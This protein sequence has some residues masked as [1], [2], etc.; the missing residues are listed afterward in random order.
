MA[1][2]NSTASGCQDASPRDVLD[3]AIDAARLAHPLI[4]HGDGRAHVFVPDGYRLED[5]TSP[6]RLPGHIVQ[7]VTVDDRASLVGYANRFRDDRSLIIADYDA[8]R[9]AAR[10]DWHSDNAHDLAAQKNGHAVI[11]HLRDSEEYVRWNEMEGDLHPQA[12]FAAFIEENVADVVDPDHSVLLEICRDLEATTG[13]AFKSGVRLENGDRSFRY[14][15]ETHVKGEVQ[16]PTEIRLAIP[17]FNG[18]A[19][20]ELRAKFRF[21]PTPGGLMLGFRWHRVEYVRQAEFQS[22]ATAAAEETGLPLFH[23]RVDG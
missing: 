16:V 11:L 2:T 6:D 4:D 7:R 8:G 5:V 1:D 9:I 10:L 23:G 17:L 19:P 14:E 3:A 12:D 18:E 21:R 13:V 20:R 15:T 22:M